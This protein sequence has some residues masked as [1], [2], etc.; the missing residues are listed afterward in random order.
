MAVL[1]ELGLKSLTD[2]DDGTSIYEGSMRGKVRSTQKGV[3]VYF[4]FKYKFQGKS[5]ELSLA[6]WPKTSLKEIRALATAARSSLDD[7]IDPITLR[8]TNKLSKAIEETNKRNELNNQLLKQIAQS[9]R[10]SVN[11]LFE[12][13]EKLDLVNRKD[14]GKEVRRMFEKDVLPLIGNLAVEDVRKAHIINVIDT[15]LSRG[16]N[17]MSKLILSLMRQMF[18]FAQDRDIIE[19][20]PTSSIRKAKIGGKDTVR[21][22]HLSEAEIRDLTAKLPDGKLLKTT[23]CAIWIMLSTCCRI[24]EICKAEWQH[25]DLDAKTWKI[26]AENSK[27]AKPHTIYLSD[28]AINQFE[29]LVTLKNSDKWIYPNTDNTDHVCEKSITKQI[30]DRQ[31]ADDRKPMSGRSKYCRTLKLADGKWTPHDL[32]RTGA[33]IMG[34]LGIRPDVIE[35]CLNH[36]EQNKMKKTYQHQSLIAEQQQAWKLLGERLDILTS[37]NTENVV[38]ID[39]VILA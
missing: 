15:L 25:L 33:T 3:S 11:N 30:G 27:N 7:G 35:K 20:D 26:P 36:I 24:G 32:R 1:T 22:R 9:H 18:R 38:S 28:F 8:K 23:E 34:N 17:R 2:K 31:L 39:N 13:W 5:K 16:V 12:R 29:K 6:S 4:D 21:D 19:N 37:K 10:L 14:G